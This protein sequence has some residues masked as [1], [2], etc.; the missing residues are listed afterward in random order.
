MPYSFGGG[1]ASGVSIEEAAR[2]INRSERQ[3]G[4]RAAA[5]GTFR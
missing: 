2:Y 3:A 5:I 4:H 1:S